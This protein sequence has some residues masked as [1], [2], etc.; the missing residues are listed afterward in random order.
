MNYET[1]KAA[2]GVI[3]VVGL[4]SVLYKEN[5]FY[6]AVE[7]L[8]LGLAAGYGIVA[9]WKE[10]LFELWYKKM[11]GTPAMGATPMEPGH[12]AYAILL[13]IGLMGYMGATK[14]LN[15]MSKIP[16]GMIIGFWA[17][18]Q[19]QIFWNKWG[20]GLK[21]SMKPIIPTQWTFVPSGPGVDKAQVAQ[22][23][24]LSQAISNFV[25]VM[26]FLCVLSYFFFSFDMKNKFLKSMNTMGRWLLMIGLGAIFGSTVMTR[27]TLVIDRMSFIWVE[28]VKERV[29]HIP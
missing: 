26:T 3:C 2:A 6:R 16:I 10:T 14:K 11:M 19:V 24:Y 1:I 15:W 29:L 23:I 5:K 21:D 13:P 17:G 7:H 9:I 22:N 18:Q 4:Y 25:F 28:F 27:F 8:F 12:W 20:P